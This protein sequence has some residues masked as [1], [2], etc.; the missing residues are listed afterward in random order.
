MPK[1]IVWKISLSAFLLS[2]SLLSA[3]AETIKIG[4]ID[5][6]SGPFGT[7]GDGGL[8]H[9]LHAAS[10]INSSGGMAGMPVEIVGFDNKIN[11]K[12]S[13]IQLQ[14]AIDQG[15]RF[16]AQGN[17]SSVA[18]ALTDAIAKHNKRNPGDELIFL[19]YAAVDPALTNAKCNYWHFRF[20]SHVDMKMA[21]LTDWLRDQK[22]IKSVY[23]LAQD[24]SFGR[25]FTAAAKSMITE[26][27]PDIQIVGT[28]LHPVAK[29]KDFTP[30]VQKMINAKADAVLTGNWS[31]DMSLL[32]KAAN[33]S[34]HN[35]PYLTFYGGG[36]GAPTA[37]GESAL[38]L[39]K[40]I[41]EFHENIETSEK[42]LARM[43]GFEDT[44]HLDM[45]YQRVY[46]AMHMLD[47]AVEAVGS[48]DIPKI[49]GELEGMT[50]E[51]PYGEVTMRA[52]D[53]QLLQPL[54]ISTFSDDVERD[55]E[56]TGFGFKTDA[57]ISAAATALPTTCKM[58]RPS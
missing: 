36:L 14:K 10:E 12:E 6:L 38:G 28:A 35:V 44:Y 50:Y 29:I 24:Y 55:V 53:H 19:N 54:Y 51:S 33:A 42:Q 56:N 46:T 11:P 7:A 5:P 32:V 47:K 15:V 18:S 39:V 21:G 26:K 37:M 49:A 2:G 52:E 16:I 48:L 4:Y 41:T 17:G 58:R 1:G 9:F 45:F 22:D 25:A 23:I 43:N 31:T 57:L 20:D 8:K 13:L 3:E 30:Y 34:G 40:Q 27:R